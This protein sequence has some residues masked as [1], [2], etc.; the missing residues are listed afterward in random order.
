MDDIKSWA[1]LGA[2]RFASIWE[3]KDF[4]K[5]SNTFHGF[6]RF[7]DASEVRWGNDPELGP[8]K[9]L[10]MTM[11]Q[12]NVVDFPTHIGDPLIWADDYGWC[13][14][15]CLA[16]RDYLL[17]INEEAL[18]RT[19]L[20]IA[21]QCWKQ[22]YNTG[23]DTTT[24]ATPVQH[25][26]SNVSPERRKTDGFG[27]RNTVTNVNL[28]ILSMRLYTATRNAEF[29]SMAFA[30]Y[31]WF[32]A[33]ITKPYN[34][35]DDGPYV[36]SYTTD[37]VGQLIHERPMAKATYI[38]QIFPDWQPG[39]V[40]TGDQGLTMMA[41]AEL[42]QMREDFAP[43]PGFDAEL[44]RWNCW[45]LAYG[46]ADIL[47]SGTDRVLREPPFNSSF[48][49]SYAADYVGG[50]GVMLR[51]ATE[52]AVQKIIGAP[53]CPEGVKATAAAVWNSREA[54]N[55]FTPL[56]NAAGDAPFNNSFVDR[57]GSGSRAALSWRLSTDISGVLQANGLDALTAAIRLG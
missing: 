49:P 52:A 1:V 5:R 29:L 8:M 10:R 46:A 18:A 27:T 17:S 20:N 36:R 16:A 22:M 39:W 40:W 37:P 55:Q 45:H 32:A 31:K 24:D 19:Y 48:G 53:F 42:Y 12:K 21:V 47:F 28:L 41:L 34:S 14:I 4:W 43:F 11:I 30:Q 51:Y 54:P 50:R 2:A 7:V 3:F 13:G 57:W 9:E 15:S 23:Y 35:L 56:W 33:W 38:E 6:L 25:G 44:V 26:C